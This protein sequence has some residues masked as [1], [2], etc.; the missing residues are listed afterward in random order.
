MATRAESFVPPRT[1]TAAGGVTL[2]SPYTSRFVGDIVARQTQPAPSD[3]GKQM[4][5]TSEGKLVE[6]PPDVTVEEATR[7]EAEAK[8]AEKQLLSAKAPAQ[9]RARR[10]ETR[11][12]RR[13][14][15]S[16]QAQSQG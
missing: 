6:L 4:F 13:E 9:A 7:L 14:K 1:S 16:S 11:Q 5:R 3:D 10:Q 8:A 12:E 15:R 2:R